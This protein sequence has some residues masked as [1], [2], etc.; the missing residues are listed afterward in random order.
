MSTNNSQY[1]DFCAIAQALSEELRPFV[2]GLGQIGKALAES[3]FGAFL[4]WY[5]SMLPTGKPPS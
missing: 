2:E 1:N 3:E 4:R 5:Q